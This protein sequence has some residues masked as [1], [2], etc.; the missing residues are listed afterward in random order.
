MDQNEFLITHLTKDKSYQYFMNEFNIDRK[1]LSIWWENG[2]DLR[3]LIKKSNQLFNSRKGT[4]E[5]T[6]FEKI[7]KN[8]FFLWYQKQ[9]QVCAYCKIEA[10]N[11]KIL[12]NDESGV[13]KTKRGRGQNLELERRDS[14]SNI[15]SEENCVLACY[16]CNNHKSDLITEKEHLDYFV[17]SIKKYYSDKLAACNKNNS[18]K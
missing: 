18:Q 8:G 17:P 2:T 7:G 4:V 16:I 9:P 3:D 15:Y 5:F 11:L 13:L 12:F 14:I 1:Q 6:E 10:F